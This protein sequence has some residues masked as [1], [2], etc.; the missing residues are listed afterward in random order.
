LEQAQ[1]ADEEERGILFL[2][3]ELCAK[4]NASFSPAGVSWMGNLGHPLHLPSDQC[5]FVVKGPRRGFLVLPAALRGKLSLDDWRPIV[6]SSIFHSFRPEF[7]RVW[8]SGV[9]LWI[10]AIVSLVGLFGVLVVLRQE[11][12][13][14]IV[15]AVAF[16]VSIITPKLYN[17]YVIRRLRLKAD[18]KA[19]DFVGRD[20][21]IQTLVKIDDMHILDLEELKK[22]KRTVWQRRVSPW[23]TM[24]ERLNN[25][26]VK[27]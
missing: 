19:A 14:F 11:L 9:A 6:A 15:I 13:A 12:F 25:L 20:Q 10:A 21:F 24:I 27:S 23:P 3:S 17:F 8:R 4:L 26:R 7:R 18:R 2:T 1:S 16:A 22:S 5:V